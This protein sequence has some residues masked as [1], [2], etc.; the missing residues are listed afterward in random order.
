MPTR[1]IRD[2]ITKSESI[3]TLSWFEEVFFYRLITI[4]DDYGRYDA[5]LKV[6]KSDL[7]PLKDITIK[8]IES[9]L[10]S[11][12]TAGMVQ[13]YMYDQRPFLQLVNWEKFQTIRNK[14]SKYPTPPPSGNNSQNNS[15]Y[16]ARDIDESDSGKIEN[17]CMQMNTDGNDSQTNVCDLLSSENNCSQM[18]TFSPE[19]Q[20]ESL[21]RSESESKSPKDARARAMGVPDSYFASHSFSQS[22]RE[23]IEEWLDYKKESGFQYKDK[24]LKNLISEIDNRLKTCSEKQVIDV[25][26]LCMANGY[27]GII[28]EKIQGWSAPSSQTQGGAAPVANKNRFVNFNQRDIDFAE[29]ERLEREQ[30]RPYSRDD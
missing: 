23:K 1:L 19:I 13:V 14:R 15:F 26:S 3:D 2:S 10:N 27:Q 7:F 29:L 16:S 24:G 9:A 17:N 5:R 8:Q 28:W 22:I 6:L 12:S 30:L 21:S 18:N 20:S 11:L 4:V 25:I